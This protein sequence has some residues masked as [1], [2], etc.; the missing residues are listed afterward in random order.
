[1]T[2]P[3]TQAPS[4][5]PRRVLEYDAA[6]AFLKMQDA[7]LANVRTRAT[8]VLSTATLLTSLAAAVGL[9]NTDPKRGDVLPVPGAWALLATTLVIGALVLYVQWTVN[10]W[11]FG[12]SAEKMRDQRTN[13]NLTEDGIRDYVVTALIH[14]IDTNATMLMRRQN[15]FRL[16]AVGLLVEV[17][18]LILA[19]A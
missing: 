19:V 12:P 7:T 18:I 17:L 9:L 4:S 16:A 5:D 2:Q 1:M 11:T 15:A 10:G 14:G 13:N 3:T 6:S 8:G